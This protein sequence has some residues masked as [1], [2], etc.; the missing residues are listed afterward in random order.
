MSGERIID[1]FQHIN[2]SLHYSATVGCNLLT[3][4]IFYIDSLPGVYRTT[5]MV[6][7]AMLMNIMACRVFRNT[8][9]GNRRMDSA[10]IISPSGAVVFPKPNINPSGTHALRLSSGNGNHARGSGGVEGGK[11]GNADVVEIYS[12]HRH[13]SEIQED[14]NRG[15]SAV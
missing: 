5:F 2:A 3:V 1:M 6:P 4:V 11:L 8:K 14:H 7:N 10:V 13:L 12:S 15:E 9:F